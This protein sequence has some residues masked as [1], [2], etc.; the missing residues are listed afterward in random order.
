MSYIYMLLCSC[1][2]QVECSQHYRRN[3]IP[4]T[5]YN[6]RLVDFWWRI[7]NRTAPTN[8]NPPRQETA[9]PNADTKFLAPGR[10]WFNYLQCN[11]IPAKSARSTSLIAR[12][13]SSLAMHLGI[14]A[15]SPR[16]TANWTSPFGIVWLPQHCLR[17]AELRQWRRTSDVEVR[18]LAVS[19]KA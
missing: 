19:W 5:A 17:K 14:G 11:G 4:L 7:N 2:P 9:Y 6:P 16:Q 13:G 18:L 3:S 12:M 1:A 10:G 15:E 8:Q